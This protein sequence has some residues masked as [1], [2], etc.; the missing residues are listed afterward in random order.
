MDA[1]SDPLSFGLFRL[2]LVRGELTNAGELVSLAPKPLALLAYLAAHRD[3]AVPK[4]ELRKHVWPDVHVSEA[5]LASALKDLRR[6]LGDDGASQKVIRTMRRRGYRFVAKLAAGARARVTP[7]REPVRAAT[8]F[9]ARGRELR[10]LASRTARASRG[11]PGLVLIR[12]EAGAGKT[13]L[14]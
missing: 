14:L 8:P 2:D 4:L 7:R 3:R 1:T 9:I 11:R 10:F 5:A 6:A 13:R 12:G